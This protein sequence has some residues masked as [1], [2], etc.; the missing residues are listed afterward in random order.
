MN[1]NFS[2]L[3]IGLILG[4]VLA[5]IIVFYASPAIILKED[6]SKYSFEES[7]ALLEAE[8]AESGWK[9]PVKHDLQATLIKNGKDEVNKVTVLE[10]CNP[11]LAEKILKTDDERVVSN[12]M[13][14]RIALYEKSDGNTY[15]SRMNSGLLAKPMG[16]VSRKQMK[17]ASND[18]E[19][20]LEVLK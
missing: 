13:P 19:D 12:M 14:C 16:K 3:I 2:F 10:L 8:I 1:K 18:I 15:Y 6:Q 9:I 11:D 5:V 17:I 4:A 7:L 20:F